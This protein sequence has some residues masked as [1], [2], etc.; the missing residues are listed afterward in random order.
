MVSRGVGIHGRDRRSERNTICHKRKC[1]RRSY[2][3]R[4]Q[5]THFWRRESISVNCGGLWECDLL[6]NLVIHG[7]GVDVSGKDRGAQ[8]VI[9]YFVLLQF[10]AAR[11]TSAKVIFKFPGARRIE[12]A[13]QV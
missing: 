2:S 3:D 13:R 9:E 1:Q 12:F 11:G 4:C 5:P 6:A 7:S 8:R 10:P